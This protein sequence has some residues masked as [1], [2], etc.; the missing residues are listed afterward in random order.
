MLG[1]ALTGFNAPN[2]STR[3]PWRADQGTRDLVWSL[4]VDDLEVLTTFDEDQLVYGAMRAGASG[5]LLKS[6][7]PARLAEAIRIIG[8]REALLAS[9][10]TCG[11]SR[12]SSSDHLDQLRAAEIS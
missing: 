2:G 7:L 5:F 10:I 8:V 1:K 9:S 6:A 12:T 4:R 11:S 3:S